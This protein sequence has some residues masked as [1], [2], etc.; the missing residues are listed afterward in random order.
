MQTSMESLH[1]LKARTRLP[2]VKELLI[3]A[4]TSFAF[5]GCQD[6]YTSRVIQAG[7][8]HLGAGMW[9]SISALMTP[10]GNTSQVCVR[11]PETYIV[12]GGRGTQ[13]IVSSAID[14][15]EVAITGRWIR[16][17][18]TII[19]SAGWA[20]ANGRN[21]SPVTSRDVC[22][23]LRERDRNSSYKAVEFQSSAPLTVSTIRWESFD[24]IGT[25]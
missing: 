1:L 21:K 10:Q 15:G 17:D 4:F 3:C 5:L 20:D 7:E 24:L 12:E 25:L 6:P 2:S 11:V 22:M 19:P 23:R 16:S 14:S 8:V 18:G 9:T 13:I